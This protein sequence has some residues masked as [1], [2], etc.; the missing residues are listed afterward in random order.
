VFDGVP[1]RGGSRDVYVLRQGTLFHFLFQP[2]VKAFPKA[3]GDV[4]ALYRAV[5]ASF[6]FIPTA[7][8]AAPAPGAAG[9]RSAA[10]FQGIGFSYPATLAQG[11]TGQVV[12]AQG[13]AG[14]PWWAISPAHSEVGLSGYLL[15]KTQQAPRIIVYPAAEFATISPEAEQRI[16][17]LRDLLKAK[18]ANPQGELPFLPLF[19]GKQA[20]HFG[21]KYLAFQGGQAVRYLTQ[22]GNGLS[23]INN[24]ALFFTFQ[25]LTADGRYYVA[26]ILPVSHPSLPAGDVTGAE[27]E[28]LVARYQQYLQE[29][30]GTLAAQP[31]ATF[32][33]GLADLDVLVQ[34]IT[35]K[36]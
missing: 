31:D 21:V 28:K 33:P 25:G 23:A 4:E 35:V 30:A 17:A 24:Q 20:L 26:A 16:A 6:A 11:T 9:R 2:D 8:A 14:E 18:P 1:G 3:A 22:Y 27:L 19:D 5:T 32:N 10:P 29:T 15:P 12:P 7:P 13:G 36:P 34:S